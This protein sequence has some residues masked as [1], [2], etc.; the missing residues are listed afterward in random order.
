MQQKYNKNNKYILLA[1]NKW[2]V[3]DVNGEKC[4]FAASLSESKRKLKNKNK[5]STD[6]ML[7]IIAFKINTKKQISVKMELRS[8][9]IRG[10]LATGQNKT[11][12]RPTCSSKS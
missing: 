7:E 6:R 10:M 3:L 9:Y 4:L 8:D 2:V 11:S 5:K 1:N 12:G